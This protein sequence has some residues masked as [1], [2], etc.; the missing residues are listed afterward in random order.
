MDK[1]LEKIEK[2]LMASKIKYLY[3][4]GLTQKQIRIV[5]QCSQ[6]LI[7]KTVN[8]HL[9]V[10][11]QPRDS[12]DYQEFIRLEILQTLMSV[13]ELP[14]Q[15]GLTNQDRFYIRLLK[16]CMVEEKEIGIT[17]HEL[18]RSQINKM[19]NDKDADITLF[20][21]ELIGIGPFNYAD[22]ISSLVE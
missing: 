12:L 14:N 19:A 6:S 17:Y 2:K 9:H 1:G 7:S 4:Y 11:K 18:S 20:N 15:R 10:R 21:S 5:L 22:F 8:E 13:P 16:L 3:E